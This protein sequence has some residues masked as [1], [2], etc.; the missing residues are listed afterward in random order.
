MKNYNRKEYKNDCIH[1]LQYAYILCIYIY[2]YIYIHI[3]ASLVTQMVKNSP[4]MQKTWVQSL[5]QAG[6]S[7]GGGNGNLENPHGQRS[8]ASYS[9]WGCKE[10]NT[11]EWL[12]HTRLCL[13][14][15]VCITESLCCTAEINH[16]SIQKKN[17]SM[18]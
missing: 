11:T 2:I 14:V 12:T 15:C 4:A 16:T 13:C 3:Q 6:G 1:M 7:P 18:K 10:L 8:L 5:G 9:P 17:V